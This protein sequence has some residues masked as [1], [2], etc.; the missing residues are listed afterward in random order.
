MIRSAQPE[1]DF[2]KENIVVRFLSHL[3]TRLVA[4]E[5]FQSQR[6]R[7]EATIDQLKDLMLKK[8]D[9][10]RKAL[11]QMKIAVILFKDRSTQI[12]MASL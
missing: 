8:E 4:C 1:V 7:L 12:D 9:A 5:E 6:Q 10:Y 2:R 11:E 3:E